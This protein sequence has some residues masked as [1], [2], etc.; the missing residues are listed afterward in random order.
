MSGM[1]PD[2]CLCIF[3]NVSVEDEWRLA[4]WWGCTPCG[5]ALT[6]ATRTVSRLSDDGR[7]IPRLVVG[8]DDSAASRKSSDGGD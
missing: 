6:H 1:Y 8:Y 5:M 7:W 3:L 4:A 2:P